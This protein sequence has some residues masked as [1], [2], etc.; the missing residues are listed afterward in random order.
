MSEAARQRLLAKLK[1]RPGPVVQMGCG[2]HAGKAV[3][4]AI[5][6]ERKIDATYVSEAVERAEFLE[7][8]TKKYGLQLLMSDSFHSLLHANNRQRCRLIDMI[9][10][11]DEDEDEDDPAAIL[12]ER[13]DL[14]SR[15]F[16]ILCSEALV[17]LHTYD[18]SLNIILPL[19]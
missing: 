11:P 4:G 16:E 10:M 14:V 18:M 8:S 3:Q 9:A 15:Q 12:Y 17:S 1:K 13:D 5:G 7:S 19:P 6:S 2:L